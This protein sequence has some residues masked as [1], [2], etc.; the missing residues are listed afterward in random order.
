MIQEAVD[1]YRNCDRCFKPM[2]I[3]DY[4]LVKTVRKDDGKYVDVIVCPT[5][6][7]RLKE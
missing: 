6:E 7:D 5:C 1:I 3:V 2:H 4:R